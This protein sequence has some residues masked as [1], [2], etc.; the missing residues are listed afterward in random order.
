MRRRHHGGMDV[1]P[2]V[3]TRNTGPLRRAPQSS[4]RAG[5]P[6]P[7]PT[8]LLTAM[9]A[10][11][12]GFERAKLRSEKQSN[13]TV[14]A[15]RQPT[16]RRHPADIGLYYLYKRHVQNAAASERPPTKADIG[17]FEPNQLR[18]CHEEPRKHP[19][20]QATKPPTQQ[21]PCIHRRPLLH[22]GVERVHRQQRHP[23]A[24][25]LGLSNGCGL[26]QNIDKTYIDMP[27]SYKHQTSQDP[28]ILSTT[29]LQEKQLKHLVHNYNI[30]SPKSKLSSHKS[31]ALYTST[32]L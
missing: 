21:C 11:R 28:H 29:Q 8:S 3:S 23:R 2:H 18:Q 32:N 13:G 22:V 20:N 30:S 5:A 25:G 12:R 24:A 4:H 27:T 10:L 6:A 26:Q 16:S 31:K 1:P 9:P 15:P 19:Q 7:P 17:P 14:F